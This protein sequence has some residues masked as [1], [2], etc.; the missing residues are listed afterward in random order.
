MEEGRKRVL[1]TIA[2]IL[3]AGHLKTTEDLNDSKPLRVL[4]RW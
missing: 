1:A 2:V 3:V 4:N